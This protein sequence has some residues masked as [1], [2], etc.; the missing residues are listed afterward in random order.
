MTK[1]LGQVTKGLGQVT[2]GLG[3][4]R[5]G[6]VRSGEEGFRS[7]E[8]GLRSGEEGFSREDLKVRLKGTCLHHTLIPGLSPLLSKHDVVFQSGVLDPGLLGNVGH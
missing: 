8:E 1:G 7:G 3:Q 5:K 4:V 6:R 2:K